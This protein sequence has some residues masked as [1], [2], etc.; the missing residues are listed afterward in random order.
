[1]KLLIKLVLIVNAFLF[2]YNANAQ[3]NVNN[4]YDKIVSG[5]HG[6]IALKT[7]GS[8]ALW[9]QSMSNTGASDLTS[10]ITLNATN[11][12][13]LGSATPL[14]ATLGGVGGGGKDQMILL[15]SDGLYAW[16]PET[17]VLNTNLTA[18]AAFAKIATPTNGDASTKLPS[19]MV[20]TD[21]SAIYGTYQTLIVLTKNDNVN[22][23]RNG[24]V[25][26]ITQASLA[27]EGN[28]GTASSV[29]SSSWLRVKTNAT[30]YLSGVI[31]VR[32]EVSAAPTTSSAL[33]ALTSTGLVYTW[34]NSCYLGNATAKVA[35]NF[36]TLMTLPSEFSA[37]NIPKL[38][39]VTGGTKNTTTSCNTYYLLS[40]SGSLYA[41]GDNSKKQCGDFTTTER[42]SW[43]NVKSSA[44][45]N[46]NNINFFSCQEHTGGIACIAAITNDG[47]LYTWGEDDGELL[48]RGTGTTANYDPGIASGTLGSTAVT[49]EMGGHTLVYLS[50]GSDHF[51]YVGHQTNGSMGCG[52]CTGVAG[53][54]TSFNCIDPPVLPICGYVPNAANANMSTIIANP[55]SINVNAT[56]TITV[57]LKQSNGSNL[58]TSGGTVVISASVGNVSSVTDNNDGTY[59]AT[60]T[61][62]NSSGSALITFSL[63]GV[64][65]SN[66]A[67]VT[68]NAPVQSVAQPLII[69]NGTL[70]TFTSIAGCPSYTQSYSVSATDLI[71]NLILT[72]P[73]GYEICLTN[74]GV[75]TNLISIVPNAGVV[76]T[77]SIFVRVKATALNGA[78][79]NITHTSINATTQNLLI[80]SA[81]VIQ[82]GGTITA[83]PTNI[84]ADGQSTSTIT[85]Q[86]VDS[87]NNNLTSG[88]A[89]VTINSTYG[90][91]TSVVDN[92]DGTYS[93]IL[94][95]SNSIT[96]TTLS[97]SVSN[98]SSSNTTTVNFICVT[99]T[100]SSTLTPASICNGSTFAYTPTCATSGATFSWS[101]A[102]VV[103]IS[104]TAGSGTNSISEVL[105]N[106]T[107]NTLNVV[108]AVTTL[109]N[110]C[111]NTENVTVSVYP[112]LSLTS[113]LTPNAVSSGTLFTYTATDLTG[114][115]FSWSRVAVTGI[116][117]LAATGT[118]NVSETLI[119]TTTAPITVSYVY[120]ISIGSCTGT[121]TVSV[122]VNPLPVLSSSLTP[123][124]VCSGTAFSY[125]PTSSTSGT[126][127][128][129][130]RA[131]V[132]GISNTVGSGT[133]S[134]SEVL[135]NTTVN[136][137]NVTYAYTLTANGDTN[138]QNVVVVV[139]PTPTLSSTLTPASICNGSIFS[140]TPQS[141]LNGSSIIWIRPIVTGLLQSAN[142]GS[143][144]INE[145][146]NN[147]T[148]SPLPIPYSVTLN[149]NG[150]VKT[151][152]VTVVVYPTPVL[153][154]TLTPS[155]VASSSVFSYTAAGSTGA[156]F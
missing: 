92:N 24:Q 96:S 34:G 14:L 108:Y 146:L 39:G 73:T 135:T 26:V 54:V 40:N 56:S 137:I 154:S 128:S 36:A 106:T 75:F 3:C 37:I 16:G 140:Y 7:D 45:T 65:S 76:N 124:A 67:S 44:S 147:L 151:Q 123:T 25:W 66:S 82:N 142:S 101:R 139:N 62:P 19:G 46:F 120:T 31:A 134:I 55:S 117:N 126:T 148:N 77:T 33:I 156:T 2:F 81:T 38:I 10:P 11:F 58:T 71:S 141:N 105:T 112:T 109:A 57:Q 8:Y 118:G 6:S 90:V 129:W 12:P 144:A 136:P 78:S 98:V 102:T 91:L 150:C 70:N 20:S 63:N 72:A 60:Y 49:C 79:G 138:T 64:T 32:G 85:V 115:S 132:V 110:G 121:Q 42:T 50:V 21:V 153:T 155:A 51:C 100:L 83:S 149:F 95:S 94:T 29:G 13:A 43:V 88:G 61:A 15:A 28:G 1:M 103:G 84:Y 27:L 127:F 35:K 87:N 143:T 131:T 41:L 5:Y 59:T 122:V 80:S 68:I 52:S 114:A 104:N 18:S 89:N 93:A 111:S 69:V 99:P 130:S 74:N 53:T 113:S 30:T 125:A 119:N 133:G 116:S 152:I 23:F 145:S 4:P 47:K 22:S 48:G 17:Y 97:F 9:G 107:A 86:L